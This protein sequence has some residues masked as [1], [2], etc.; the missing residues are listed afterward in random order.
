LEVGIASL[1]EVAEIEFDQW[2][3]TQEVFRR[4]DSVFPPGLKLKAV[5]EMPLLRAGRIPERVIYLLHL[6]EAGI[7]L[8]PESLVKLLE[9][10]TL[11][12][13]RPREKR[14]QNVDLRPALSALKL[15]MGDLE[16]EV[17]P[18]QS[19]TAR[20]LEVL[21]LLTGQPLESLKRVRVTKTRM[22]LRNP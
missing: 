8:P 10:A 11:P 9:A 6:H 20:P 17:R 7:Q 19:G 5:Q 13:Q 22:D 2:L 21:C 4:L 14:V 18:S 3:D 12:F 15:S 1:D 16:I